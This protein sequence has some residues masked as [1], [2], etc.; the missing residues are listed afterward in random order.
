[1]IVRKTINIYEPLTEEQKA[2]LAE[3][4]NLRDKDIVY[5]ED[6]SE[7]T[8]EQLKKFRRVNPIRRQANDNG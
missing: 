5:D 1:M 6:C 8:E 4:K 3:L 7:L 2:R